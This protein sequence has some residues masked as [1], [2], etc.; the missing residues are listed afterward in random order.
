MVVITEGRRAMM[1]ARMG[2]GGLDLERRR[3]ESVCLRME[4]MRKA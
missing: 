4:V 2:W 1:K 3:R